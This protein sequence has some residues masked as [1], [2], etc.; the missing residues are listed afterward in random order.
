MEIIYHPIGVAHT[1]FKSLQEMSGKP[2]Q[3][4]VASGSVEVFPEFS[5]GLND[6]AG[7]SHIYLLFHL[8]QIQ[9][10]F[11]VVIPSLD[12]MPRGVFSTRAPCRPNPIALSLVKLVQIE[13]NFLYVEGLDVLEGTP[14]LD[15]KPYIPEFEEG[16]EIRTGWLEKAKG[17]IHSQKSDSPE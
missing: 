10:H 12:D 8:H 15:I 14:L 7:F 5:E 3:E 6:L 9:Q 16:A 11:L 13:N 2:K 4:R 17:K 1:P